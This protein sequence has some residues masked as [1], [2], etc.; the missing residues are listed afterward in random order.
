[1]LELTLTTSEET[2][3]NI[4]GEPLIWFIVAMLAIAGSA[5]VILFVVRS[6]FRRR[7]HER[8]GAFEK[9]VLLVTLP[10]ESAEVEKGGKAEERLDRIQE[11]IGVAE[12]FFSAIGG[13]RAEKGFKAWFQGREDHLA[14]EIVAQNG[15]ISFYVAV[16]RKLQAFIEQQLHAQYSDASIEEVED[17]NIFSSQGQ[18]AGTMLTGKRITALPIKSYRKIPADPLN[19]ITNA[20]S[21]IPENDGA[22][23]Q[24]VV[25]S[26]RREWRRQA[27]K[28]ASH[29]QQGKRF[30][31]AMRL[32][33]WLGGFVAAVRPKNKLGE[34]KQPEQY[35]LSP[36]EEEMVKSMEE[37]ASKLGLDVN[38]RVL[39]SAKTSE[40]ASR[41]LQGIT[42][43]FAQYDLPQ[44]GNVLQKASPG[45]KRLI[46]DFIFRNF[47]DKRRLVLNTE[48][49]SSLYHFPLPSTETPNIR[50]LIARKSAPP[51]NLPETGLVLGKVIYRGEEN[52]VRIKPNDRLR[53]IYMIGRSGTGKSTIIENMAIQDI[54]NGH[55]VCVVDPHGD[56]VEHILERFPKERADDVI[57]FSPWDTERPVGL[58]ML[59]VKQESQKDFAVQEMISVFY[60]LFP[61]EMIG[62]MFEHQ[63]RNIMLTLMSDPEQG[64]TIAEIPR[65]F[66]DAEYQKAWSAKV[67]DPVV[68][69]FW[70]K[71]MA[72][73]SDFHKSEMLG[74][75]I[76]KVGRFA[77][78]EMMRNIVG[79][80]QS[81]FDVR[82]VMDKKKVLLVDLSKGK[83]GEVNANLLGLIIVSKL[84]MAALSRAD[85]PESE[86]SDF[87]LYIDEF[88]NFVTDSVATILSEAR[89]YKL[90]L[91]IA[92][93]Y[94]GQLSQNNDTKI[95][96]AVLGNA[97]TMIIFRIGIEDAEILEKEFK[98][99][100]N[101]Y[102]LVN[103]ENRTAYLKLLIDGTAS[104]PFN[105]TTMA[106]EKGDSKLA[107][108]LRQL[109]RLKYGRPKE[110]VETEILE[111]S[112]LGAPAAHTAAPMPGERTL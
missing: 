80:V 4:G 53:H 84:Q 78:N 106:P 38:I 52:V 100:F 83:T 5:I 22:A 15:L 77:E 9:I 105:M 56:L 6:I 51:I 29:M 96:D 61:P 57:V 60:K 42:G 11:G 17:Y 28:I 44:Y 20:M 87:Y 62:P 82:E 25:R 71:E 67:K 49:F 19:A 32:T 59:E 102:D 112:Q 72:K 54:R 64:G 92:H 104:K 39:A 93:Q 41:V 97:G 47:D 21:K 85:M 14:F 90:S 23:I 48:E 66:S 110:I 13:L 8:K 3:V 109:S 31:E 65:M 2:S 43:S 34:S 98:P 58:N 7:A 1:M 74:Y 73:M 88:Q 107:G 55:G 86:R 91:N 69:A 45:N 40:E 79:Q 99:V 81:G 76:S 37:K 63:M 12:V 18:I 70:E 103:T 33:T 111:R 35:R 26:A 46:H 68:R 75:L 50:W 108:A 24:Y 94:M 16:P 36:L 27:V 89:K 10:K 30:E 95:R 101:A